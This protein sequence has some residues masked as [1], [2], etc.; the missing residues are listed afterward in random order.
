M[1]HVCLLLIAILFF[2]T[3]V[4]ATF[5]GNWPL[6]VYGLAAGV[7]QIAVISMGK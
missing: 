4:Q 5:A 7:L 1:N 3:A 6:V 2:G